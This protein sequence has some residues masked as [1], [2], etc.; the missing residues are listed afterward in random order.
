MVEAEMGEAP[1]AGKSG[2]T[3]GRIHPTAD[4]QLGKFASCRMAEARPSVIPDARHEITRAD[5]GCAAWRLGPH[6]KP[7]QGRRGGSAA[8]QLSLIHI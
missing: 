1:G 8:Q 4:A 2:R 6:T 7:D 5:G 3:A